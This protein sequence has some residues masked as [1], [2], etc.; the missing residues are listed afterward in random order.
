MTV[1]RVSHG[2]A[3]QG[4]YVNLEMTDHEMEHALIS[5][6]D[7]FDDDD[8][9]ISHE[10]AGGLELSMLGVGTLSGLLEP[11]L[12]EWTLTTLSATGVSIRA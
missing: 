10:G 3:S 2:D 12:E 4:S 11:V 5:A 7:F 8:L 1:L 6:V 9:I